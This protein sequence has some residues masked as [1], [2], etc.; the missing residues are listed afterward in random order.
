MYV[1]RHSGNFLKSINYNTKN[2]GRKGNWK[3]IK[4]REKTLRERQVLTKEGSCN[5]ENVK[6]VSKNFFKD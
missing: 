3:N 1:R 2:K 6:L 5:L 4:S